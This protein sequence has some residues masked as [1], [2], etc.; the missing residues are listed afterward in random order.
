M[1]CGGAAGMTLNMVL[2]PPDIGEDWPSKIR[3]AVPGIQ[4]EAFAGP[5]D[6]AAAIVD[7]DAAHGTCRPIRWP[8]RGAYAG[9]QHRAPALV[10]SD[11]T[12]NWSEPVIVTNLR[13]IYNE[14]LARRFGAMK[15]GVYFINIGRGQCVVTDDLTAV[16]ASGHLPAPGRRCGARTAPGR[17]STVDDARRPADTA[18]RHPRRTLSTQARGDPD[19]EPPSVRE[20]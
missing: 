7:A 5:Q 6:A 13:G 3:A 1:V 8:V 14:N 2:L 15:R 18:R 11:S 12:T 10:A 17:P 4:V 16:L 19:R 20:R 9:S